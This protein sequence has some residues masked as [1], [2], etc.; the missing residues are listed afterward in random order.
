MRDMLHSALI[1]VH[2]AA[3]GL[4]CLP[5]R[6]PGSWRFRVYAGSLLAMLVFVAGAITVGW[7]SLDAT[8]RVTFTGLA[9]LGLYMVWRA[10]R[11]RARLR[12]QHPGWQPGYLDDVGFTL[13]AL[14]DGFVIV[15]AIDLG[16]QAWL[17]VLV[18]VAGVAAGIEAMK[19]VKARLV[20]S[21]PAAPAMAAREARPRAG[22]GRDPAS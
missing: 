3:A 4:A 1:A 8:A 17:V 10:G 11:A 14:F 7:A 15:G 5:L 2:D 22:A 19:R 21:Q 13:I 6:A 20:V 9:A 16:L 12:H 18:A